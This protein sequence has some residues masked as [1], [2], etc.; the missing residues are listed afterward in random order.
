MSDETETPD[1][2]PPDPWQKLRETAQ[3][4]VDAFDAWNDTPDHFP[5]EDM[6]EGLAALG[7]ALTA[8]RD[9]ER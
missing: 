1:P 8:L 3:L 2:T 9:S 7:E 4:T 5:S 6:L